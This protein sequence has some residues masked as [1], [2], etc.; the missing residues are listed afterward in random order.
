MLAACYAMNVTNII[1]T[2]LRRMTYVKSVAFII[3][4]GSF[5]KKLMAL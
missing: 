1:F 3:F 4:T 2:L 5:N